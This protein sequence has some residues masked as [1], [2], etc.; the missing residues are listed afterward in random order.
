MKEETEV[1]EEEQD[2]EQD[3]T[4]A[5]PPEKK[6]GEEEDT[7]KEE[8]TG[9]EEEEAAEEKKGETLESLKEKLE[10]LKEEFRGRID[11]LTAERHELMGRINAMSEGRKEEKSGSKSWDDPYWTNS[12][13]RALVEEQP[14][15]RETV[16]GLIEERMEKRITERLEGKIKSS[17]TEEASYDRVT[18]EMP[19]YAQKGTPEWKL[20]NQLYVE[21]GLKGNPNGPYIAARLAKDEMDANKGKKLP[22][23]EALRKKIDKL[24]KKTELATGKAGKA[25]PGLQAQIDKAFDDAE[26]KDENGSE[27]LKLRRLLREKSKLERGEKNEE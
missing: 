5:S 16:E 3:D 13:L 21:L 1:K 25:S 4:K 27:W 6:E 7:K 26:G 8:K 22:S 24:G 12:R 23:K 10:N 14:D 9:E 15:Y 20:A 11:E 2:E 18:T 17:T 19:E